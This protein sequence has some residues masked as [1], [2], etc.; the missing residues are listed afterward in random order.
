MDHEPRER[1]L[2]DHDRGL[3]F[4]LATLSNRR[5]LLKFMADV[6]GAV[7]LA[8]DGRGDG[9]GFELLGHPQGDSRS[10]SGRRLQRAERAHA[11][12]DRPH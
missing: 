9:L 1:E 8:D 2:H 10:L 7:G 6:T 3:T 12:R 11:E 4:D 5:G